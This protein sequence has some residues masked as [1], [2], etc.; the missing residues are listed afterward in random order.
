MLLFS[1]TFALF[2]L[3]AQ[4]CRRSF[5]EKR[6]NIIAIASVVWMS[7]GAGL[8]SFLQYRVWSSADVANY[9]LPP[10]T[11]ISYFLYYVGTRFFLPFGAS[12]VFAV[13]FVVAMRIM[14][15]R[16]GEKF[17]DRGEITVAGIAIFL[18]GFPGV[19]IFV[20][21][22]I[23]FY[24]LYHLVNVVRGKKGERIPLFFLWLPVSISVILINNFWLSRLDI[25]KLMKF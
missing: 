6:Q 11:D 22:L 23:L 4:I 24:L 10:Y 15:K 1:V 25:W 14:N 9:L 19:L 21:T 17:F 20:P 12:L 2:L 16:M 5:L 7:I 13:L 3:G 8:L 18:S